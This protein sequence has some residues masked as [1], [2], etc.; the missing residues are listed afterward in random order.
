MNDPLEVFGLAP[1]ASEDE[2]RRRYLELVRLHPPERSPDRFAEIRAA[3]DAL[4]DPV[5]RFKQQ[6]FELKTNDTME[7]IVARASASMRSQRRRLPTD[8]LLSLGRK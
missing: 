5:H 7:D 2:I 1:G 6:F 8:L 4:S 3:Y